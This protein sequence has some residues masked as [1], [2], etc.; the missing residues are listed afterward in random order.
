MSW[1]IQNQPQLH[2]ASEP[3]WLMYT[4]PGPLIWVVRILLSVNSG[5]L[6]GVTVPGMNFTTE[7]CSSVFLSLLAC[8]SYKSRFSPPSSVQ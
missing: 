6:E 4:E 8:G 3:P 1:L 5:T 7:K 2:R